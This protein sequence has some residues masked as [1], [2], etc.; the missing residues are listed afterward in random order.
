MRHAAAEE[1]FRANTGA[2][3]GEFL[4]E[5]RCVFSTS[6][7][8]RRE[9]DGRYY[10]LLK[11]PDLSWSVEEVLLAQTIACNG[12]GNARRPVTSSVQTGRKCEF[13]VKWNGLHKIPVDPMEKICYDGKEDCRK[14]DRRWDRRLFAEIRFNGI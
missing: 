4:Y 2:R 6:R 10:F 11:M 9:K 7:E 1:R 14:Q 8:S 12:T 3:N 13:C 5:D